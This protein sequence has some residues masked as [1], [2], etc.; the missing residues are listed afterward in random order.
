MVEFR[1]VREEDLSL[2]LEWR[3]KE[4]VNKSMLTQVN[5]TIED[6]KNWFT[7]ISNNKEYRYWVIYYKLTP[8][9]VLNLAEID[10]I[11][12]K[13]SA[14]YYIGDEA[15]KSLGA[16]ILPYLYNYVFNYL[17]FRKIFGPVMSNNKSIRQIHKLHGYR[18]VGFFE[19]HVKIGNEFLDIIIVEL[20]ADVWSTKKKYLE[21]NAEWESY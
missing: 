21:Y 19:K 18:E 14:G 4:F 11:N 8:I 10:Q 7:K 15:Y 13:C 6:Q 3:N 9:G 20:M 16:L 1:K 5:Q 17:G 2:I 12:G